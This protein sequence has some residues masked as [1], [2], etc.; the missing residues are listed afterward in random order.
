MKQWLFY[1][2][3]WWALAGATMSA[4]DSSPDSRRPDVPGFRPAKAVNP[5]LPRVLLIGDS[6]CSGY[7]GPVRERLA[8][9]ANVD[10]WVTGANV[11]GI[12]NR[13]RAA[14][15]HGPYAVIHFNIGLHGLGNRIAPDEYE[16][17]FRNYV[18]TLRVFSQGATLIWASTTP[19]RL[20]GTTTPHPEDTPKIT[21]R[22]AIA[23][24]V[25][26]ANGIAV[27]DLYN[28]AREHLEWG[29]K[30]G[31]HWTGEGYAR[32]AAQ[33]A[34]LIQKALAERSRQDAR[35]LD[36]TLRNVR[37]GPHPE[38][39]LNFWRAPGTQTTP[40]LVLIH[41]GGWVTGHKA[42][43][44][45]RQSRDIWNGAPFLAA[46]IS[47]VSIGYRLT[48]QHPLP[49]PVHDAA[50]AVQFV[51]F[52]AEAWGL[53]KTRLAVA[54]GSAGGASSLWLIYHDDL[55]DPDADDPV[56]RESSKPLC[57]A[58]EAPQTC[59]DPP[60][61]RQWVGD[62]ILEHCMIANAVGSTNIAEV[63]RDYPKYQATFREFSAYY[64]VDKNDP[65]ALLYCF[66]TTRIPAP[67]VGIAIH[68]PL[69]S[70]K[71]KEKAD[72]AGAEC[73][74]LLRSTRKKIFY[75]EA[76]RDFL[77]SKLLEKSP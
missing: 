56:A 22:N 76:F 37:Y 12:G 42:E 11:K 57:A 36:P 72:A 23:A 13:L 6:I 67:S 60:L 2:G 33:I 55:A 59:I 65:P 73:D 8:G 31:V 43:R 15:G 58:V 5:D 68:D 62:K 9:V 16:P 47:V 7:L 19:T 75:D 71:L 77:K 29:G 4:G 24:R 64:H 40:V 50:R 69:L 74:F 38:N 34:P 39:V 25:A 46:G 45:D 10:A 70:W 35:Y 48:P 26:E 17:L 3:I 52:K 66:G 1:W 44:F 30:D 54:G 20:R 21:R 27:N 53:D 32:M 51:R 49:A 14:L 63:L 61:I 41:G 18:E 28:L